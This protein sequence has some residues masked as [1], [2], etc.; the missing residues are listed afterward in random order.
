M[1]ES[2]KEINSEEKRKIYLLADILRNRYQNIH[3][4]ILEGKNIALLDNIAFRLN[5]PN[6]S[7]IAALVEIE[8]TKILMELD[9]KNDIKHL[10][11]MVDRMSHSP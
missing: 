5:I 6:E 10:M 7:L 4:I 1:L 11:D 9:Q 2:F 3:Q 8:T